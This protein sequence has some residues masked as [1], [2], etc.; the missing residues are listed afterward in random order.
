MI[1]IQSAIGPGVR[2]EADETTHAFFLAPPFTRWR[3]GRRVRSS[4]TDTPPQ[5]KSP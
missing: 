5:P 3:G 4:E 1:G 2:L